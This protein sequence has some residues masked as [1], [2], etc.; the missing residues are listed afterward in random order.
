MEALKILGR[1]PAGTPDQRGV[2]YSFADLVQPI[3]DDIAGLCWA[4]QGSQVFVA[5]RGGVVLP[6]D[7]DL[8]AMFEIQLGVPAP[9]DPDVSVWDR[10][11]LKPEHF[12]EL[13]P[14]V[15]GDWTDIVG[16]PSPPACARADVR[17]RDKD[18]LQHNARVYFACIDAAVWEV[19]AQERAI[20]EKLAEAFPGSEPRVL[21]NGKC[22][23]RRG[24]VS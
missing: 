8:D 24:Q 11:W 6:N 16:I 17:P 10:A 15:V 20:L 4:L 9:P 1:E 21:Q 3:R 7:D 18:W 14:L 23:G 12:L 13:V 22:K 5:E 19:Y 2:G